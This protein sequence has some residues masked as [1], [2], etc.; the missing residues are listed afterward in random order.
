MSYENP[1]RAIDTQTGQHLA[2]LQNTISGTFQGIAKTYKAEQEARTK[3]LN[4]QAEIITNIKKS[5][6]ALEDNLRN[7][8]S[9]FG[10]QNPSLN[11]D[12][13]L[14]AVDR[15]ND[16]KNTIDLGTAS[17][18]E[19]A[20]LR[21]ELSEIMALPTL[22][23]TML[24]NLTQSVVGFD[25]VLNNVGKMGG[26]DLYSGSTMIEDLRVWQNLSPG[27][28]K[29]VIQKNPK[30]GKWEAS[31]VIN[32][33]QYTSDQLSRL[34]ANGEGLI[35]IVSDQ[36]SNFDNYTN[37]VK[38]KDEKT[39]EDKFRDGVLG[40]IE[41]RDTED[42]NAESY[43]VVNK[44]VVKKTAGIEIDASISV[45]TA[46]EK[47]VFWNNILA[48]KGSGN[49][50]I[51]NSEDPRARSMSS[52]DFDDPKNEE[53]FKEA[54]TD[55]WIDSRIGAEVILSSKRIET[56]ELTPTQQLAQNK[57]KEKEKIKKDN[58]TKAVKLID[59]SKDD[60]NFGAKG[61][62]FKTQY[63]KIQAFA[64]RNGLSIKVTQLVD[65]NGDLD[66]II[67]TSR[68]DKSEIIL[69]KGSSDKEVRDAIKASAL[70]GVENYNQSEATD[71]NKG[72]VGDII[73]QE[74][75]ENK[76]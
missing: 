44:E 26:A 5:N 64:G 30:N 28:R 62:D 54:Y 11:T 32:G 59:S 34:T 55:K 43:R 71:E 42:G 27:E 37:M 53:L 35:A 16:I 66:G 33:N 2:N 47:A 6:Q 17:P 69:P 65:S 68:D 70:G 46:S 22:G 76:S 8:I 18:K 45:M 39:G 13:W 20:A 12:A 74:G 21:Q 10:A 49:K 40:P 19:I 51:V 73:I 14:A 63:N 61:Y 36:T 1:T 57:N 24:E 25:K 23:R 52:E 58:Y 48:K 7:K 38:P 67:I 15:V 72:A 50:I 75:K 41:Y 9:E 56:K 60:L 3:K 4:E 29:Q 31:I